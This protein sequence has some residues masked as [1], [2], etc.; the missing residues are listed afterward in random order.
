MT[1]MQWKN[2]TTRYSF[3]STRKKQ[4]TAQ[5]RRA[6]SIGIGL[7]LPETHPHILAPGECMSFFIYLSLSLILFSLFVSNKRDP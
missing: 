4:I 1:L 2:I 3:L 5:F 6:Y 7:P